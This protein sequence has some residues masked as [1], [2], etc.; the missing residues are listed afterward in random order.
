MLVAS[1]KAVEFGYNDIPCIQD[2]NV[3]IQSGEFVAVTGPNGAAKSTLLKLMLGLLEPW[4]G[5]VFL[6]TANEEGRKLKVGYVS[7]QIS[8]FNSGFPSTI[9]EFVRSG[10]YASSSWFRKLLKEDDRLTEITLRQVGMW[11]LRK[12]KIGELSGGQKQRIC[13]ARALAQE[14]DLLVLDEPTTG[15]DQDSRCGFYQLMH[16]QVKAHGRTVIMVTHNLE[17][18]APYLNRI[19]E[20]ERK[21]DGGWKCCTTTSCSGHFVPVG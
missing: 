14:P 1:L 8:A 17:E 6:S 10:R 5:K 20:L 16:H 4:K 15:M 18:A 21:E 2:A 11:D 13:I 12:R 7:Q 19:I 9:L 3:E